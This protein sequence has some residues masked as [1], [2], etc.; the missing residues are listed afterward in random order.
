MKIIVDT[1]IVFSSLLKKN[2]KFRDIII[3]NE[4]HEFITCRMLLVELFKHKNKIVENSKLSESEILELFY[5][6]LKNIELFNESYISLDNWSLAY[7]LC[8][9][10]D[11]K[12]IVFIA[13]TL[14]TNGLLWTSDKN[15]KEKLQ[16]KGFN[17]FF[18]PQY[19]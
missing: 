19:L 7:D 16:E 11:T 5:E 3:L 17:R 4:E 14:E 18:N 9:D 1:N 13:L 12:D 10:I 8:H 2:N 15:L 6:I